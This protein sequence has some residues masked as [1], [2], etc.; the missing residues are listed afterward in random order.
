MLSEN[1]NEMLAAQKRKRTFFSLYEI[2][3]VIILI[4]VAYSMGIMTG[5]MQTKSEAIEH[6]CAMFDKSGQF[7]WNSKLLIKKTK[8]SKK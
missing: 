8:G 4:I 5:E 3:V 1:V 7:V 2:L 6:N